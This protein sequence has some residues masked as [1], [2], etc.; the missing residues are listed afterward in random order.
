MWRE[1]EMTNL[2]LN[3][4]GFYTLPNPLRFRTMEQCNA[5]QRGELSEELLP[6]PGTK[7]YEDAPFE[8]GFIVHPNAL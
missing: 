1:G 6:K 4:H 2:K 7:E 8:Q 3:E 5:Y